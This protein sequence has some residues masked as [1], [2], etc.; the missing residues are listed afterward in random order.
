MSP[1]ES[2]PDNQLLTR[3]ALIVPLLNLNS[4]LPELDF[5]NGFKLTPCTEGEKDQHLGFSRSV[6]WWEEV[7]VPSLSIPPQ[8][9]RGSATLVTQAC[10]QCAA[11]LEFLDLGN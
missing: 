1:T 3:W 8:T 2:Q 7:L 6:P 4:Q 5:G 9:F 10:P 11:L